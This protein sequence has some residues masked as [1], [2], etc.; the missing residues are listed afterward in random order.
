MIGW[1][2]LRDCLLVSSQQAADIKEVLP[3]ASGG[4]GVAGA[5]DT[6]MAVTALSHCLGLQGVSPASLLT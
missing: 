6:G 2:V 1:T 5:G 3:A 4:G